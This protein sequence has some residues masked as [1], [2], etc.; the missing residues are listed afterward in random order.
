MNVP[1]LILRFHGLKHWI[2]E[3]TYILPKAHIYIDCRFLRDSASEK[4]VEW[5]AR[6]DGSLPAMIRMIEAHVR[7]VPSR[8]AGVRDAYAD[9]IICL[10]LCA[11]RGN[12]SVAMKSILSRHLP[13]EWKVE[14]Q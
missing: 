3:D 9:P 2:G 10:C 1:H 4:D 8:R 12:R 7:A 5:C 13:R 14:V 11:R 6:S